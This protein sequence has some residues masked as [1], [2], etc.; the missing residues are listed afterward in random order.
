MARK[1]GGGSLLFIVLV[2]GWALSKCGGDTDTP[3]PDLPTP[4]PLAI[5]AAQ[6]LETMYVNVPA[7]NQRAAPNGSIV[8]KVIG[9]DAVTV[10]DRQGD[11]ARISPDSSPPLWVSQRHLCL[12][13]GCYIPK[14]KR[15]RNNTP[16]KRSRFNSG[17][18]ECPCS[19]NRVCIGP[20]G[21]RYCITSG[22]NKR[23]GV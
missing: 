6:P 15:I 16:T 14:Q 22:G 11:W 9:G 23:Y 2:L 17:D 1:T 13:S 21:G 12:G 19:G 8:G 18:D 10:Y 3:T 5:V 7:L 4:P 20:R